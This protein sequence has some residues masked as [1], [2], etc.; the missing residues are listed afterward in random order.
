MQSDTPTHINHAASSG[1]PGPSRP[2]GV[3]ITSPSEA[4]PSRGRYPSVVSPRFTALDNLKQDAGMFACL[5]LPC[6]FTLNISSDPGYSPM[7][8]D[9]KSTNSDS[10]GRHPKP[11][12]PYRTIVFGL[13]L[14]SSCFAFYNIYTTDSV[15]AY[16]G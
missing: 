14:V 1:L 3:A 2:H 16:W 10:A 9:R 12:L 6:F 5:L 15:E 4:T 13:I 7:Q 11:F 8:L